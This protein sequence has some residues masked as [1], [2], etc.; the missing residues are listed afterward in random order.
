MGAVFAFASGTVDFST[1]APDAAAYG[2]RFIFVFAALLMLGAFGAAVASRKVS[3]DA[4]GID[5]VSRR[6]S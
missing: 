5:A 3:A 2:M 1:T 4:S 6:N